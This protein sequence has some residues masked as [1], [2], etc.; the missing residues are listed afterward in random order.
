VEG[1]REL[2]AGAL[3]AFLMMQLTGVDREV[4]EKKNAVAEMNAARGIAAF[5]VTTTGVVG[6]VIAL[7]VVGV[8]QVYLQ[9]M[10]GLAFMV[11]KT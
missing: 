5:W 6:M 2:I 7:T 4:V 11:V 10:A 1:T 8:V 9:R 3:L